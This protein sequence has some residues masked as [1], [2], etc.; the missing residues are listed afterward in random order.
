MTNAQTRTPGGNRARGRTKYYEKHSTAKSPRYQRQNAIPTPEAFYRRQFPGLRARNG[1]ALVRCC[2][3]NDR[4]PSLSINLSGGHFK[5]HA[6][7]AKGGG[8]VDFRIKQTGFSF[9]DV[10]RELEGG[11]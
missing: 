2:F 10:I 9:R 11:R 8:I 7:G 6:C 4:N 1:W 3:H 5:C